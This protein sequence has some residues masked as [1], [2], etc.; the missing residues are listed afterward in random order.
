MFVPSLS[1]QTVDSLEETEKKRK[2]KGVS[3]LEP[4]RDDR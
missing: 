2:L 4:R 3:H 1:W